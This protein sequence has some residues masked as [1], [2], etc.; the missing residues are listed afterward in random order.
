MINHREIN[1][2]RIVN[3]D[4]EVNIVEC[5]GCAVVLT[6]TDVTGE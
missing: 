4:N 3:K 5:T 2:I 1:I 6:G